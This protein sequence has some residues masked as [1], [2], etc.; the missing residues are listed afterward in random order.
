MKNIIAIVGRPNVGKSTFF[1]RIV[2][3]RVSIELDT[4]GVT[5][6]RIYEK[7][8][9]RDREFNVIDTGGLTLEKADFAN[10]IKIQAEIAI[11]EASIILFMIDGRIG[12]TADEHEIFKILK[13]SKKEIII[14]ANKIDNAELM[15]NVYELYSLG[16]SEVIPVSATHGAGVYDV[17][18]VVYS[19]LEDELID[20]ITGIKFSIIGRPNVGKS[21]LFNAILGEERSIVSEIEGTTRDTVNT[22]FNFAGV[23]YEMIDTAGIRK[24]GKVFDKVEKYSV[25]RS[26]K[27]IE[28]ADIV[29]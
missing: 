10:E 1:N 14:V 29:L 5:R 22:V 17:L 18:D 7:V 12:L 15:T 19:K 2:Q 6:D 3:K 11:A 28:D 25:L 27:A 4:P 21:T 24:R 26:L 8:S 9:Y 23:D 16:V 20:E 13:R